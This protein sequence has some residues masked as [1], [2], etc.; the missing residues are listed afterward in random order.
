M[1]KLTP[2]ER[3]GQESKVDVNGLSE[4]DQLIA[5]AEMAAREA[6]QLAVTEEMATTRTKKQSSAESATRVEELQQ[7]YAGLRADDAFVADYAYEQVFVAAEAETGIATSEKI[8]GIIAALKKAGDALKNIGAVEPK[9]DALLN[10]MDALQKLHDKLFEQIQAAAVDV[11]DAVKQKYKG[12]E[13]DFEKRY[14]TLINSPLVRGVEF[15]PNSP[16]ARERAL[17]QEIVEVLLRPVAENRLKAIEKMIVDAQARIEQIEDKVYTKMDRLRS[18]GGYENQQSKKAEALSIA[19]DLGLVS[20]DD[21]RNYGNDNFTVAD[22]N[23]LASDK[24]KSLSESIR[25]LELIL[26][27]ERLAFEVNRMVVEDAIDDEHIDDEH[28][29]DVLREAMVE[30][31]TFLTILRNNSNPNRDFSRDVP[32]P[33]SGLAVKVL[34]QYQQFAVSTSDG[35]IGQNSIYEIHALDPGAQLLGQTGISREYPRE[36]REEGYLRYQLRKLNLQPRL[37]GVDIENSLLRNFD[38]QSQSLTPGSLRGDYNQI[39]R[40]H[41]DNKEKRP[42]VA[43]FLAEFPTAESFLKHMFAGQG[44]LFNLRRAYNKVDAGLSN[45]KNVA[46][47]PEGLI[48]VGWTE[49]TLGALVEPGQNARGVDGKYARLLEHLSEPQLEA[50]R[51]FDIRGERGE[52]K[53]YTIEQAVDLLR[54]ARRDVRALVGDSDRETKNVK[55]DKN[56]DEI[57]IAGLSAEVDALKKKLESALEGAKQAGKS[58]TIANKERD[59]AKEAADRHQR[60]VGTLQQANKQLEDQLEDSVQSVLAGLKSA[61]EAKSGFLGGE[62]DL[63]AAVER[64]MR[65]L[66]K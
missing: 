24:I 48:E 50:E 62:K 8:H 16:E 52:F 26:A 17:K 23:R 60:N 3:I 4:L 63:R 55:A 10:K 2:G 27:R 21:S 36:T 19:R 51:A 39:A 25:M 6:Q 58:V 38:I 53:V 61:L 37:S 20:K 41:K 33:Q 34:A 5:D 42:E 22:L 43:K 57:K 14:Q 44:K 7:W 54:R 59:Q 56:K 40:Q 66:E 1:S 31:R 64:L 28:D 47:V 65:Q 45:K 15:D 49:S 30:L 9:T 11:L 12:E 32:P 46:A 29:E 13:T 18:P 35:S